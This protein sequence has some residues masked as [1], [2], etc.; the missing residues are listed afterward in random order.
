VSPGS[1]RYPVTRG[2][3]F[4]QGTPVRYTDPS[5]HCIQVED[6]LCLRQDDNN[7]LHIVQAG[8][9][10]FRNDVER[11]LANFILSGDPRSL[12]RIPEGSPGFM[13]GAAFENACAGLGMDCGGYYRTFIFLWT[14]GALGVSGISS[15]R[16]TFNEN[17]IPSNIAEDVYSQGGWETY[18]SRGSSST[19]RPPSNLREAFA[20]DAAQADPASGL[21]LPV[22]MTDPRW[23]ASDGWV[24]MAQN[25]NGIEVHFVYNTRTGWVDD[26]KIMSK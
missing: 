12:N 10:W 19:G 21:A 13:V 17:S 24:K 20:L 18:Q 1:A 26:L 8:K 16:P 3:S 25:I 4:V 9:K 14:A 2:V 6:D 5:G 11:A 23:P 7:R 22:P 15:Y